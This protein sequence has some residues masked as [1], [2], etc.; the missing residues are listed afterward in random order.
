MTIDY[1]I[2]N[3]VIAAALA[4]AA[5]LLTIVYVSS[6]R[7]HDAT[8]KQSVTVYTV[9][10]NYGIGTPGSKIAGHLTALT[11]TRA[12]MAPHTVTNPNQIRNLYLA[13][14]VYAGEQLSLLRFAPANQQ[15]I[16]TQ[17]TGTER[18][19]QVPGDENQLLAGTLVAGDRVDVVA[20][21]KNPNNQNDI[22][23][24]VVLRNL[25]VLQIANLKGGSAL[26]RSPG[27][28]H[29]VILQV[30]DEQD[31]RLNWVLANANSQ[32]WLELRPVKK[33]KDDARST[34]TF[35]SVVNGG[36]K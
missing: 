18:A 21:L 16:R 29:A 26:S 19:V 13:Q 10:G 12:Q 7:K 35:A 25:L 33:P 3:I 1:R 15:G 23:S 5:V 31:Q 22:Q 32:W 34:T 2:R 27:S 30:T 14:P 6:A 8:Q 36:S 9:N 17:L 28:D 24:Q 20:N 4:A 11:V